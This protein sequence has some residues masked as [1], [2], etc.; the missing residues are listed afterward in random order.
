[1]GE[2]NFK[3]S[4]WFLQAQIHYEGRARAEAARVH[5]HRLA[6]EFETGR[7]SH[8]VSIGLGDEDVPDFC[9]GSPTRARGCQ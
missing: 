7:I 8:E 4:A 5:V 3:G 9:T 1:M 6:L 2:R